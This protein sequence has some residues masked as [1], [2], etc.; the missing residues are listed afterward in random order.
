MNR[1]RNYNPNIPAGY[2]ALQDIKHFV[3]SSITRRLLI[4]RTGKEVI[5]GQ[6]KN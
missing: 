3:N 2:S 1:Y 4:G 6:L 5:E